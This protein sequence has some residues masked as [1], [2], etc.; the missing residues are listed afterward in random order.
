MVK[1]ARPRRLES[2]SAMPSGVVVVVVAAVAVVAAAEN[3]LR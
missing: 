1:P 2:A 3:N